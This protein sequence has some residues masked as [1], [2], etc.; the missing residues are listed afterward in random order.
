MYLCFPRWDK[1]LKEFPVAVQHDMLAIK[2][3]MRTEPAE[4]PRGPPRR[5]LKAQ[6]STASSVCSVDSTGMPVLPPMSSSSD[7]DV[8]EPCSESLSSCN[9]SIS[10]DGEQVPLPARKVKDRFA[11]QALKAAKTPPPAQ[12]GA[13]KRNILKRPANMSKRNTCATG[14]SPILG[15]IKLH[16]ATAKTYMTYLHKSKWKCVVTCSHKFHKEIVSAIF[17]RAC[18]EP[19]TKKMC[20]DMKNKLQKRGLPCGVDEVAPAKCV[21]V[22]EN[23]DVAP[24]EFAGMDDSESEMSSLSGHCV[25]FIFL[26]ITITKHSKTTMI[27]YR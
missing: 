20:V 21:R 15:D 1:K 9:I 7:E 18:S 8:S 12:R 16:P 10:S 23:D 24:A 2:D 14:K 5:M 13:L 4:P 19:M 25:S 6:A 27:V 17:N 22:A 11:Q 3:L 26:L